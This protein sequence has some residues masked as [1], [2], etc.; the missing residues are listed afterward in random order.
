MIPATEWWN[1]I[2]NYGLSIFPMQFI[3]LALGFVVVIFF[4]VKRNELAS[5]ILKVYFVYTFLWI[6]V[7][8]FF[9]LGK[10]LPAYI[11]QM[12]LFSSLGILFA[13]DLKYNKIQFE[14]PQEKGRRILYSTFLILVFAYPLIGYLIGS[15]TYPK[16]II[17]GSY[18]CPTAAL[19]L[20]LISGNIRK[21]DWKIFIL[22]LIWAI[23]FPI[24][25]QIPQFGV[26][27]D[28]I[29]LLSGL[30][31]LGLWIYEQINKKNSKNLEQYIQQKIQPLSQ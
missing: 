16:I 14:V 12:T 15:H 13:L 4:L 18:P 7:I 10:D 5:R 31:T 9:L 3:N 25:I 19:A 22:L 23:P 8:F 11:M 24:L 6:G 28:S 1:I 30:Y 2:G 29:M 17:L 26:Y 20:V 21:I 27:E